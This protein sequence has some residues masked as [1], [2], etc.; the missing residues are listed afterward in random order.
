MLDFFKKVF[1]NPDAGN[2]SG[3]TYNQE[4]KL[5]V[6]TCAL[7]VQMAQADDDFS[8][9]ERAN[10]ISIMKNTFSLNDD[11]VLELLDLSEQKVKDSISIYEFASIINENFSSDEKFE[12]IKNLWRL[13]YVDDTLDKYEDKLIKMIAGVLNVEHKYIIGAKLLVQKEREQPL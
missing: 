7:F 13:I 4:E 2:E 9:S 10:I 3:T 6:A 12:L 8:E 11:E 1:F 5:R